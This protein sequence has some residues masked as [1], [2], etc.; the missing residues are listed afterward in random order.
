MANWSQLVAHDKRV[1]NRT[2]I[3]NLLDE[4][5]A[6]YVTTQNQNYVAPPPPFTDARYPLITIL[7]D[8]TTS[9]NP[10]IRNILDPEP[11]L[12]TIYSIN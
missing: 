1:K 2:L 4:A 12:G 7:Q 11:N 10:R 5:V 6:K 9:P 8:C 3:A